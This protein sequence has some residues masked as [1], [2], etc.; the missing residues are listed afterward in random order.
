MLLT[1]KFCFDSRVFQRFSGL[2]G[3]DEYI[4]SCLWHGIERAI[5]NCQIGRKLVGNQC[6]VIVRRLSLIA[7]K[8]LHATFCLVAI[9]L[10]K[11]T[12]DTQSN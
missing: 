5:P 10:D 7:S 9:H 6:F 12:D 4:Y 3:R 1:T 8:Q 2:S 11:I